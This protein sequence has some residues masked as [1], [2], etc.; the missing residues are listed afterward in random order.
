MGLPPKVAVTTSNLIIGSMAL[1]SASVYLEA[2]LIDAQ[3]AAPVILGV[4][5][6]SFL[7]SKVLIGITNRLI[8]MAFLCVLVVLGVELILHG[9]R[10]F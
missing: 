7:G 4:F 9:L 8:R 5:L 10:K 6:G 3:L 1:A 2:G